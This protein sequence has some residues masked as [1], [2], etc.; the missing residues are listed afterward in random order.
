MF[1]YY[2]II[3]YINKSNKINYVFKHKIKIKALKIKLK[4]NIYINR[5]SDNNFLLEYVLTLTI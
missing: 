5:K 2:Y 4:P 3:I 1:L